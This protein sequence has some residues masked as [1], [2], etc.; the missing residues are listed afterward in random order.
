MKS[1]ENYDEYLQK[2]SE[3]YV[4]TYRFIKFFTLL[5]SHKGFYL[6]FARYQ[7]QRDRHSH[8]DFTYFDSGDE[9]GVSGLCFKFFFMTSIFLLH[10][11]VVA[12][13]VLNYL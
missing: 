3:A 7:R 9:D 1:K 5:I 12:A 10:G 8:F 11:A 13:C 6:S 2:Y 4:C